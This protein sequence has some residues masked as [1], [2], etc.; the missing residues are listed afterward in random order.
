MTA[1]WRTAEDPGV[2]PTADFA[3][4][5]VVRGAM[6]IGVLDHSG[7]LAF[8]N[9]AFHAAGLKTTLLDPRGFLSNSRLEQLRV[10]ALREDTHG[11]APVFEVPLR[12]GSIRVEVLGLSLVPGWVA[13][14]VHPPG[15]IQ[16]VAPHLPSPE[17]LLHELRAPLLAIRVALDDLTQECAAQAPD[18][19]DAVGRQSRAVAHLAG[20]LTGLGD[21][22][23]ADELAAHRAD[24]P[25][26]DLA[27]VMGEVLKS[28][29]PLAEL[30]GY[31][32]EVR[33]DPGVAAIPG[34]P[35]LLGRAVANLID[36]ALK[37]S[38]APGPIRLGLAQRGAL[39]VVEVADAGPAIAPNDRQR[40]FEP[41]VRLQRADVPDV[42]GSGL[43]LAVVQRVARA[44]GGN[45]SLESAG[46]FG[47]TFRLSFL[48]SGSASG[49]RRAAAGV[50]D[51][52]SR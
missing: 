29:G 8:A 3:S 24:A 37:Y 6:P 2:M 12:A 40:L 23:R 32:L 25:V 16:E 50:A 46:G 17:L 49:H 45:L 31:R 28:Y 20:V 13:M 18:L 47:N 21:L 15:P 42:Q 43:G 48:A 9:P 30:S 51:P 41:F 36:N 39:V 19:L 14:V 1:H 10:A 4:E 5:V 26:V 11:V 27:A 7:K 22:V 35:E 34:D 33:M 38:P 44:H 52:E